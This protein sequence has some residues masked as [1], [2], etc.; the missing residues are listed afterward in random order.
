[1][2]SFAHLWKN[3]AKFSI[4][5]LHFY[6]AWGKRIL[7]LPEILRRNNRRQ[8]LI[9][10]GAI[11]HATA[12]IGR[13]KGDGRKANLQIGSHSFIGEINI[14][15]YDVVIIGDKVCINDGVRIFTAS[16]DVL[17]PK[18]S[19]IK[20]KVII[21]DYAWIGTGAMILPGVHI[22]KGS[23][24]GAGAV[25]SKSVLPGNIVVGNPAK[26]TSKLRCEN[27]DYDPCEYLAG[28]R[29]WLVG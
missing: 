7:T 24:V 20:G 9:N 15:L 26:I 6:R 17:D 29:A 1:M 19:Y 11:I 5:S 10:K 23:V 22:G 12:E 2:A 28:N 16:H 13:M 25:V 27:L 21:D 14:A 18:W 4:Y 3:R 8:K